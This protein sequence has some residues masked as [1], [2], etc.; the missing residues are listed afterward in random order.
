MNLRMLV[1][2]VKQE[3]ANPLA[4]VQEN[5]ENHDNHCDNFSGM[6]VQG[7]KCSPCGI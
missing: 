7:S 4:P 6:F 3:T 5:E 2:L 1:V